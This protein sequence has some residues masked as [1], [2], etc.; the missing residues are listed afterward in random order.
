MSAFARPLDEELTAISS[1]RV[2]ALPSTV[3]ERAAALR[4]RLDR[5]DEDRC[6]GYA[7]D[8]SPEGLEAGTPV[9]VKSVRLT[10][11]GGRTG[12]VGV[13]PGSH[14]K[15][16]EADGVYVVALYAE[17]EH[18]GRDRIVLLA[19]EI[20]DAD[21]IGARLSPTASGYQ[22]VRWDLLIDAEV[23]RSRWSA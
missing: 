11:N 14:A 1:T 23:D 3:A 8:D 9:E 10:H 2:N 22:K 5:V 19:L 7:T 15:L 21:A 12:R 6:D 17:L 20:V 13:H 18:E 16:A 4:Y